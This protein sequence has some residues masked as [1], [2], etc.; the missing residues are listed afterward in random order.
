MVG[1]SNLGS[2]NGHWLQNV[3]S[4]VRLGLKWL[5]PF[6]IMEVSSSHGGTNRPYRGWAWLDHALWFWT[7]WSL[8]E[9]I[10]L[11]LHFN[12]RESTNHEMDSDSHP[13]ILVV[14]R[15]H[16]PAHWNAGSCM[17]FLLLHFRNSSGKA[18]SHMPVS[19]RRW[20]GWLIM[21]R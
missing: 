4:H 11:Q 18:W 5:D 3:L 1:T 2:W 9:L 16:P 8:N 12:I 21:L 19:T 7:V 13:G 14:K 17:F 6:P 20:S 15:D 10:G